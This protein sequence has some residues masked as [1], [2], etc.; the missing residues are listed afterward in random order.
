MMQGGKKKAECR[1]QSRKAG[2][3]NKVNQDPKK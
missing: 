2:F 1:E 3:R